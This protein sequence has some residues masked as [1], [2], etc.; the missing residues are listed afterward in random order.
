MP[1]AA[2]AGDAVAQEPEPVF[3]AEPPRDEPSAA[4]LDET[5]AAIDA[6]VASEE[7][8]PMP[9]LPSALQAQARSA[10]EQLIVFSVGG[11]DY[12]VA[13][14]NIREVDRLPQVTPIPNVP[15]WMIGVA[16][17]RG[18]IVSMVDLRAFLG[19]ESYGRQP[20]QRMLVARDRKEEITA[21]LIVDHVRGIRYVAAERVNPA[22]SPIED[23]VAPYL[24][25]F[26][27]QDGRLLVLLDLNRL[28]LSPEMRQFEPI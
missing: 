16:N 25:G 10:E 1:A 2:A 13:I 15:P 18:D 5:L 27:E 14:G 28:L 12:G 17:V 3:A 20:T 21:G 8:P 6:T 24:R 11:V 7:A 22:A 23:R 4:I 9:L 26:T 19:M